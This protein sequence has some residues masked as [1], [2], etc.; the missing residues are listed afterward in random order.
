MAVLARE[1]S[2]VY[3]SRTIGGTSTTVLLDGTEPYKVSVDADVATFTCLLVVRESAKDDFL[4]LVAA[5]ED[6]LATPRQRL[7]VIQAGDEVFDWNPSSSEAADLGFNADPQLT[8]VGS[9]QV[10]SGRSQ[11]YRF[12]VRIDLPAS[13]W[14]QDGR[15][16]DASPVITWSPARQADITVNATYTALPGTT[17]AYAVYLAAIDAYVSAIAAI[18]G[19]AG[20]ELVAETA[21]PD[22]TNKVI[23]V[24]R[25][26]RQILQRQTLDELDDDRL[27]DQALVVRV[28]REFP[29]D[30]P[31]KTVNRLVVLSASYSCWVDK[32]QTTDLRALW[33]NTVKA[34][35]LRK[36]LDGIGASSGALVRDVPSYDGPRNRIEAQVEVLAA[37]GP[38]FVEYTKTIKVSKDLGKVFRRA[39]R[40]NKPYARYRYQ[41]HGKLTRITI[42][43]GRRLTSSVQ[44][45]RAAGSG[46]GTFGVSFGS[47]QGG[48]GA[49][50]PGVSIR[51]P[52]NP[53][54]VS[55]QQRSTLGQAG[56]QRSPVPSPA[57]SGGGGA[58][59]GG[60]VWEVVAEDSDETPRRIGDPRAGGQLMVVDI[61]FVTIEEYIE[62]E[63]IGAGSGVTL[64]RGGGGS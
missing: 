52:V 37:V 4:A 64:T 57:A 1:L 10:D 63:P 18:V 48:A 51:Y 59:G 3:G 55:T 7:R 12:T 2:V 5:V 50:G 25:V 20:V 17:S 38:G 47:R 26:Y 8:K 11:R 58:G 27:V 61:V 56:S 62:P 31:G 35:V 41:G 53:G 28:V 21:R 60:G 30:S 42:E 45:L 49:S 34:H 13:R 54:R 44:G 14:G 29:G 6:D 19:V 36:V 22:D 43:R 9:P 15:R 46:G 39:W 32:D 33:E 24:T 23:R 40:R 16:G